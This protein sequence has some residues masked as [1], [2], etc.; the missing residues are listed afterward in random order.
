MHT[1]AARIALLSL[2]L[3][4]AA[5][6]AASAK[7]AGVAATAT[8]VAARAVISTTA[9]EVL[10][11]L[12]T[13]G[14]S[15][16]Q[17]LEK[18]EKIVYVRFNLP[19][20]SRLV[21]GKKWRA[22]SS[23]QRDTYITEF[24]DYIS[25]YYGSRLD[26]YAEEDVEV[27]KAKDRPRGDVQVST[28]MVGGQANGV[29][30][31]YRLRLDSG[32]WKIIDVTIEHISLVKN[33]REQFSEVVKREGPEGLIRSLRLKNRQHEERKGAVIAEQ[34]PQPEEAATR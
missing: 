32:E 18:L 11:V 34:T 22:F 30:V 12:R 3:L 8:E 33:F 9:D 27:F 19:T 24:I 16:G 25:I 15:N 28:R 21:L 14:L 20:M 2:L 17:R 31:D 26:S 7:K 23:A 10:A 29:L 13:S 1:A 4:C 6:P 5:A